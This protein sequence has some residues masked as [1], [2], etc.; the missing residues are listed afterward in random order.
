M[1]NIAL[2]AASILLIAIGAAHSIL[3]ER[4]I[5]SRALRMPQPRLSGDD[6][7]TKRTMRFA[8]HVT[9]VAWFG[10]AALLGLVALGVQMDPIRV[11]GSVTATTLAVTAVVVAVGSRGRHLA[12]LAFGI[13]AVLTWVGTA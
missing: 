11:V 1:V 4:Y 5:I 10:L 8:W 6:V 7:F 9:T 3:G 12:W 2:A 13:A